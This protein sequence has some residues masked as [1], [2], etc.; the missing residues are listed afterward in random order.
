MARLEFEMA[1]EIAEAGKLNLAEAVRDAA[2]AAGGDLVFVLPAPREDGR[3]VECAVVRLVEH[4]EPQLV[5]VTA[6]EEGFAF[7]DEEAI[8][9]QL[10]GLAKSSIDVFERLRSDHRVV[11]PL[12]AEERAAA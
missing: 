2:R 6:T 7:S 10:R 3:V 1:L 8:D 9:P 12:Q 5:S 4:D 11:A